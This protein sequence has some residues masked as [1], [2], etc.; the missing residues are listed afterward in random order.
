MLSAGNRFMYDWFDNNDDVR[1]TYHK[2]FKPDPSLNV[3][4]PRRNIY[5]FQ[6]I[7]PRTYDLNCEAY[8]VKVAKDKINKKCRKEG[9][10]PVNLIYEECRGRYGAIFDNLKIEM[11]ISYSCE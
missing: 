11:K 7:H 1:R 8:Y 5:G 9:K 2:T 3:Y 4:Q 6:M 10:K